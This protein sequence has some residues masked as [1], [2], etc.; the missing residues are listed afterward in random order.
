MNIS[1]SEIAQLLRCPAQWGFGY[2]DLAGFP[3]KPKTTALRLRE[4]RA[5]GQAVQ[6]WHTREPGTDPIVRAHEALLTS[7]NDD[8]AFMHTHGVLDE[9]EFAQTMARMQE[10]LVHY[11]ATQPRLNLIGSEVELEMPHVDGWT[12]R[13]HLDGIH[14]DE[15]GYLWVVEFKLRTPGAFT[16]LEI[17][18]LWRQV[19]WYALALEATNGTEEIRFYNGEPTEIVRRE[20][21]GVI[22]DE[23]LNDAPNPVRYNKNGSVSATQSCLYEEYERACMMLNQPMHEP[24]VQRL[25]AKVWQQRHEVYFRPDEMRDALYELESAATLLSLYHNHRLRPIRNPG[26]QCATCAFLPLCPDYTDAR[27][28]DALFTPVEGVAA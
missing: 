28:R 11:C 15:D 10:I 6:A 21:R 2:G 22:V 27:L 23:R 13:C 19:R 5:W 8:A 9:E 3:L 25:Q 7:L 1:Q 20:I 24:T 18:Q 12:Y 16:S 17:V 4:G 14:Q 26:R